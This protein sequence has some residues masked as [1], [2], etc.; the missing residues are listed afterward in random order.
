MML[1]VLFRIPI[2]TNWTPDGIPVYGFGMM[3]FVAFLVCTWLAGRR[4]EHEGVSRD[5]IQDLAIW[6]F[7]G[8]LLGARITFLLGEQHPAS[9]GDFFSQL[10]RIWDGGIVLYGAVLGGTAAYA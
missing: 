7:L 6:I 4:A 3:L 10:P 9:V 2:Y 5:A 1:Q 8:G